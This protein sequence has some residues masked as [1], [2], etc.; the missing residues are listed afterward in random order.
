MSIH[1]SNILLDIV[2]YI[3]IDSHM[4]FN[5]CDINLYVQMIYSLNITEV[6]CLH[7]V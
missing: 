3:Y 6:Y 7:F 5:K 2:I 4:K 1:M